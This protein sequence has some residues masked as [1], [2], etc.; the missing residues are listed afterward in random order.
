MT[1]RPTG[2]RAAVIGA[3]GHTGQL[4]VAELTRRGW[5]PILA[6][7]D[8][9]QLTALHTR[10]PA[11]EARLVDVADPA[12]LDRA[13]AGADVVLHCAG[14]FADTTPA[15]LAAA[16]RARVPYL[17]A[18]AEQPAVAAAFAEHDAAARAAGVIAVPAMAFYGGLADLLAT[19]VVAGDPAPVD[20]LDIAIALDRWFPTRGTRL[21]GERQRGPRLRI[22]D[23]RL[24]HAPLPSPRTWEFPPPFG[25]QDVEGV[26]LAEAV[27]IQRHLRPA[28]LRVYLNAAPL[29]DLRDPLTPPPTAVDASGRSAQTFLVDVRA[30]RGER[31]GGLVAAGRDI[32]AVSATLMVEA[33]AH[34]LAGRVRAGAR[35]VLAAGEAFDPPA[36]LGALAPVLALSATP[37]SAAGA[38]A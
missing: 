16:V 20:R 6:G 28:E 30:H 27:T 18:A 19:A 29:R 26:S 25:R 22:A 31:V 13:L 36:L 1:S 10:T 4:V 21:T 8:P 3:Y 14:P 33:A 35:G 38:C 23:H 24:Q 7:R 17:D 2:A 5:T 32:Y 12:S 34:I 9:A 37:G 15:V 11:A